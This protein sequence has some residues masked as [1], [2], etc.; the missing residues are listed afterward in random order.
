MQGLPPGRWCLRGWLTL[1]SPRGYLG[2]AQATRDTFSGAWL[3]TGDIMRVD[4][5]DN[6]W[7]TDRLK[8]LIKYKG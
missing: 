1:H 5:N 8:E 7:I 2:D 6:F 4:E 3:R